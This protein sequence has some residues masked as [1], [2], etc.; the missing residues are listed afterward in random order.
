MSPLATFD[1][2]KSQ[3]ADLLHYHATDHTSLRIPTEDS[4]S[5]RWPLHLLWQDLLTKISEL[6]QLGISSIYGQNSVLEERMM[7]MA[8]SVYGYLKRVAAIHC[9][10]NDKK[11]ISIDNAQ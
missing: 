11:I 3:I 10:Q 6:N 7:R 5:S 1:D 2:F 8:I 9:V 4:N